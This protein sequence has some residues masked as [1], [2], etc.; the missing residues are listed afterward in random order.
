MSLANLGSRAALISGDYRDQD[1]AGLTNVL[2]KTL[3]GMSYSNSRGK[4]V[5]PKN[6]YRLGE[7]FPLQQF[8]IFLGGLCK[9]RV[10]RR[11]SRRTYQRRE[12]A[13]LYAGGIARAASKFVYGGS[14]V[15]P[16]QAV[17]RGR[18]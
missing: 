7:T 12:I 18:G 3:E 10:A 1:Y 8:Q 16:L 17:G 11:S 9:P 13:E 2:S 4:H 6:S 15:S 14:R 5:V